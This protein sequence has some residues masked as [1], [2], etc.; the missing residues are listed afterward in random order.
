MLQ[1]LGELFQNVAV[2]CTIDL[3]R[4]SEL[5]DRT[6]S[7]GKLRSLLV[8]ILTVFPFTI[9][10][11]AEFN[12]TNSYRSATVRKKSIPGGE[13]STEGHGLVLTTQQMSI[14]WASVYN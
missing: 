5:Q 1:C 3:R 4:D 2:R 7:F 14:W 10:L 11:N 9:V 12:S 13:L 8:L 6:V